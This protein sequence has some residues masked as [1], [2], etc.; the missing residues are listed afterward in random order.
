MLGQLAGISQ[1]MENSE[2]ALNTV[3]TADSALGEVVNLLNEIRM[4]ALAAVGSTPDLI[5]AEQAMV[6]AAISSVNRIASTTRFGNQYLLDGQASIDVTTK[7]AAI[8]DLR[9]HSVQFYG[10]TSLTFDVNVTAAAEQANVAVGNIGGAITDT[11]ILEVSGPLGTGV[12]SIA[13]TTGP[14][15]TATAIDSIRST[16][17]VYASGSTLLTEIYGLEAEISVKKIGGDAAATFTDVGDTGVD[18][19]ATVNGSS[20]AGIGSELTVSLPNMQGKIFVNPTSGIGTYTFTAKDSGLNFQLGSDVTNADSVNAAF[21]NVSSVALGSPEYTVGGV[22]LGGVLSSVKAGGGNDLSTN[23]E[24]A[25][26]IV[27]AAL[28]EILS[29]R[30]HLGATAAYNIQPGIDFLQTQF[31]DVSDAISNIMDTDYATET[32]N[33]L[34]SQIMMEAGMAVLA[35]ATLVP[36]SVLDLLRM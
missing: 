10:A 23:P 14:L 35:Q 18:I 22:T 11:V 3:Q 5:A 19:I 1:A 12:V 7:S 27:N 31:I 29:Y 13:G 25:V 4:S 30:S 24:N 9:L 6:D 26:R 33:L 15:G 2:R 34:R 21:P 36:T 16:T 32:S 20:V 8:V 17:G 28:E